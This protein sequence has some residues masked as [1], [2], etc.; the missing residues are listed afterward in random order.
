MS[1]KYLIPGYRGEES[2][3]GIMIAVQNVLIFSGFVFNEK[4]KGSESVE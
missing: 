4:T 2:Y 3:A 1:L